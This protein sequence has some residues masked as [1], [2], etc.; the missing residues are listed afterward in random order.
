MMNW[1]S[2]SRGGGGGELGDR[3]DRREEKTLAVIP[4]K[5]EG[6]RCLN[7]GRRSLFI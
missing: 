5:L 4:C 2:R 1:D 6:R 3:H 7:Q